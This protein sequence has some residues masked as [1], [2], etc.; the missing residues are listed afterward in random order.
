MKSPL[1]NVIIAGS[2]CIVV[3]ISYG[4]LYNYVVAESVTVANIER[5]IIA[6]TGTE[7]RI[8]STRASLAEIANDETNIQSYFIPETGV[9]SF[10]DTLQTQARALNATT[11][12][13]S[14][15]MSGVGSVQAALKTALT[16]KG[17]FDSV[18]RTIGAI[19]YMPYDLSISALSLEQDTK[20]MWHANLNLV[21]GSISVG[22]ATSTP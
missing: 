4:A 12:I 10:I 1:T 5:Q 20:N 22:I 17:T 21:V 15:S 13:L 11:S 2:V 8:A 18:M 19:E 3:M 9:V 6:K 14:V 16:I 7:S